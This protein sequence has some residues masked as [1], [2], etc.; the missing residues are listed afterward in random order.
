MSS[1]I[2]QFLSVRTK[3]VLLCVVSV[4]AIASCASSGGSGGGGSVDDGYQWARVYLVS[5]GPTVG[6]SGSFWDGLTGTVV[7]KRPW[8][9]TAADAT[10]VFYLAVD[11]KNL[12][13]RAE[14]KD[15]APQLR[16]DDMPA[17]DAWNG[18]SLQVFFG[19]NTKR[20][21]EYEEG[22][23]GISLWVIADAAAEG[24]RK[25]VAAKG[26]V[27]NDRQYTAAVVEWVENASYTIEVSFP[28]D[29]LGIT[30]PFKA[31]Q[32]VRCEFRI[33][34]AKHGEDR[35][36]IVNWRTSSDDAWK[37][38]TTWSDGVVEAK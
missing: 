12:Y 28:L 9:G 17:G 7:D 1:Y 18:T 21:V 35:T 37:D 4:F 26:R 20:H 10:G 38:T 19:T 5:Q 8:D 30:K 23:N 15:A 11:E 6:D 13:L 34:H 32:K 25:V 27:L 2:K 14:I 16:P 3:I 29:I 36:V 31:G 22:D 33:N 24:G